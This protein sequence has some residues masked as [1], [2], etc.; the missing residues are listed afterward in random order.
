VALPATAFVIITAAF[1]AAH[2]WV[3]KKDK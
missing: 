1:V 2:F 3:K